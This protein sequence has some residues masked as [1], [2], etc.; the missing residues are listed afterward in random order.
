[1]EPEITL[2]TSDKEIPGQKYTLLSFVS[3]ETIL[4]NKDVYYF[5][6][7]LKSYEFEFKTKSIEEFLAKTVISINTNLETKAVEFEKLD[8]S[9]S[10]DVCRNSKIRIDSVFSDLQEFIKK[11]SSE[12]H[13]SQLKDKYDDYVALNKQ[14]LES[15]F[16]VEN[17]FQTSTR[18]LKI[19][20][21]FG[22]HEEAE[23][24]ARK[25][26]KEDPV[27]NIYVAEVGKWLPWDPQATEVKDQEY[28]EEQLNTLM[29]KKREN[30]EQKET[31][32]KDKNLKRPEKIK[33]SVTNE[34]ATTNETVS[35]DVMFRQTGDL[36]LD[37]KSNPM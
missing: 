1:M 26:Q 6:Q 4:K 14:K 17:K 31:F 20:G 23:V 2:L 19:R 30:E 22:Y 34:N 5:N 37:R 32:F 15:D 8:L 16:Y 25:L 29:K 28:A 35:N 13:E 3:P 7:F 11:N 10:A 9:G 33:F 24:Y 21:T 18:G 36:A 12:L 27:H